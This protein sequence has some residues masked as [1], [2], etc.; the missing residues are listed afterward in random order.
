MKR[1][2]LIVLSNFDLTLPEQSLT[3]PLAVVLLWN[4]NALTTQSTTT[5]LCLTKQRVW[6]VYNPDQVD[7][8]D[9]L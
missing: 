6:K 7:Q 4:R 3:M 1:Q 2:F 8:T 5:R 9:T